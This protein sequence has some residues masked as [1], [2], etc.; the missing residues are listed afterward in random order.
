[1]RLFHREAFVTLA[2]QT[3]GAATE[4]NAHRF[5]GR[6]RFDISLD[7]GG[8]ANKGAIQMFNLAKTT[9]ALLEE[10]KLICVLSAGYARPYGDGAKVIFIGN[11][12]LTNGV[13]VERKAADVMTTIECGD[14]EKEIRNAVTQISLKG[15]VK[16][17][18]V[19]DRLL[20]DFGLSIGHRDRLPTFTF[21]NGF[22]ATGR[23]SK[24]LTDI[25][26]KAGFT[27]SVQN[28][29]I[30]ILRGNNTVN[31]QGP[32]ISKD[33]G[34]VGAVLKSKEKIEFETLIIP[35][36]LPGARARVVS[37]RYG[38]LNIKITRIRFV[39]DNWEGDWIQEVEAVPL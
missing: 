14:A 9:Q 31:Q 5:N 24:V 13:H 11:V 30:V 27:W 28:Y 12:D 38:E 15:T 7:S 29:Q 32:I 25:G 18:T 19:L 4:Q 1:M 8:E 6:I 10:S 39:G 17:E 37:E 34:L 36:I 35:G 26:R 2:K 16:L 21:E 20:K 3:T 33:S 23:L 22:S